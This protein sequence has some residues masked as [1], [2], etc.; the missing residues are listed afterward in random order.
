[1]FPYLFPDGRGHYDGTGKLT[2]C[3]YLKLRMQQLFTPFTPS[4]TYCTC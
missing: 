4:K 3:D 2:L 1:M